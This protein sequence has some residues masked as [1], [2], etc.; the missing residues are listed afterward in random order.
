[1][2]DLSL[3]ELRLGLTDLLH[4]SRRN[5]LDRTHAALIYRPR[6]TRL[7][8]HLQALP[9]SLIELPLVELLRL[10]DGRRDGY[11]RALHHLRLAIEALPSATAELT[12]TAGLVRSEFVPSLATTQQPYAIAADSVQEDTQDLERHRAALATVPT[13]D[14]RTLD[15]W[16][17]DFIAAGTEV[18][19]LLDAR[20]ADLGVAGSREGAGRLRSEIVGALTELRGVVATERAH[21]DDLPATIDGELFGHLDE[22]QRLATARNASKQKPKPDAPSADPTP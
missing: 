15:R 5:V 3:A 22:L 21:R 17:E 4:G 11:A 14:G 18:K 2:R 9:P 1:M 8:E 6:L 20:G 16:I 12:A 13:P 10:A 19:N 7:F